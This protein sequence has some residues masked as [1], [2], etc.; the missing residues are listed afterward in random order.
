MK[1]GDNVWVAEEENH[2]RIILFFKCIPT[3]E[4]EVFCWSLFRG[5]VFIHAVN[6]IIA[7]L[8]TFH[9][10]DVVFNILG[11]SGVKTKG[12]EA[13]VTPQ[14]VHIKS[15]GTPFPYWRY[16][17]ENTCKPFGIRLGDI[18]KRHAI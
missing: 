17:A 3:L 11:D 5:S 2:L 14:V 10:A 16:L 1:A 9:I 13:P 18:R 8:N 12:Q 15:T 6:M 7:F 4:H